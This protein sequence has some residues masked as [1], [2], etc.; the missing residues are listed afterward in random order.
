ML[1]SWMWIMLLVSN[2]DEAP[3]PW[4]RK[5]PPIIE[6]ADTNPTV[7]AL[8]SALDA[9]WR[10]DDWQAGERL[11]KRAQEH[12]AA[13]VIPPLAARALWRAGAIV[14]A[15]RLVD[16]LPRDAGA[17]D[18]PV[19]L[20]MIV[21][22]ALA[23]GQRERAATAAARLEAR[24]DATASDLLHAMAV[25]LLEN[26]FDGMVALLRRV[27][28][29]A[30]AKNGY[31]EHYIT[32]TIDGLAEYFAAIGAAPLNQVAR[33]G[34]A[35]MPV[36]PLI[37]LP[38]CMVEINGHGPYRMILD[39]GG[40]I[41]LSVDEAVAK[42]IGLKS[43]A[44]A[45]VRGVSGKES[46]G[47]AVIEEVRIG[48]IACKRVMTR[49]F[50]VR[51]AAAGAV[52]GIIGT[53]IFSDGRIVLDF[54]R[55]RLVVT[56]SSDEP[57]RGRAVDVRIVGDSKLIAPI[58]LNGERAAALLDSGA[59]VVA[60]APSRLKKLFPGKPIASMSAPLAGVGTG[61]APAISVHSGVTLGFGGRTLENFGGLGLDTLDEVLGPIL[62]VQTDVLIGMALFREM[63]T[64]TIDFPR[65]RMWI[66]WIDSGAN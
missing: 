25:R 30:D 45:S 47:Q 27:E 10:A 63:R 35:E 17:I 61:A 43:V 14:D 5:A 31:P 49:I 42:E 54:E 38:G 53:G 4:I 20:Q 29:L 33:Y 44:E 32:E 40:S 62:G 59:D 1:G 12:H 34:E 39:T 7:D 50:D 58:T 66:E 13:A 18:D 55:G 11:A 64:C 48:E 16:A 22:T 26:R 6:R 51:R 41:T 8:A 37:N 52:D 57:G 9:A 24:Q 3:N 23:R 15:E 2:A 60:M 56:P 21:T 36:T 28:K 19:A 46:S 65:C